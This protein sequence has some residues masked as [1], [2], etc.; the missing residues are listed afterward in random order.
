MKKLIIFLAVVL[1]I[2]LINA[3]SCTPD[4]GYDI[5]SYNFQQ[6]S[7]GGMTAFASA[8]I[9][10]SNIEGNHKS[11]DYWVGPTYIS[12]SS[13]GDEA[14]IYEGMSSWTNLWNI[15][16]CGTNCEY[17]ASAGLSVCND[18][19]KNY[20]EKIN[21]YSTGTY[22][23]TNNPGEMYENTIAFV[24]SDYN[25]KSNNAGWLW[26]WTATGAGWASNDITVRQVECYEDSDC[27]SG[28][29]CDRSGVWHQW[30]CTNAAVCSDSDGLDLETKGTCTDTNGNTYTDSC[31]SNDEVME[32]TCG[33]G[34]SCEPDYYQC[35]DSTCHDGKCQELEQTCEDSD[36]GKDYF[37]KGVVAGQNTDGSFFPSTEENTR[38]RCIGT[39]PQ[40]YVE[41]WYCDSYNLPKSVQ[42][43]CDGLCVNDACEDCDSHADERC[44]GDDLYWYDSCNNKE[45]LKEQCQYGCLNGQC[46][47]PNC[48]PIHY[49]IICD[50]D[51]DL[52]FVD[53][54]G[55]E[56]DL[57]LD[58]TEQE[59][60]NAETEECI[61]DCQ[62]QFDKICN[63]GNIWWVDSCGELEFQFG[64]D[65]IEGCEE[66]ACT[67][68]VCTP[69]AELRC[70]DNSVYQYDSCGNK[71][72][73]VKDCGSKTC[74]NGVCQGNTPGDC[75]PNNMR[76]AGNIVQQCNSQGN[77]WSTL[78]DCGTEAV[79]NEMSH[80]YA[81]CEKKGFF[82]NLIEKLKTDTT[83]QVGAIILVI[84]IA[85]VAITEK[86]RR[87]K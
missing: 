7:G 70:D 19:C 86:K 31:R 34:G 71:G 21:G 11:G 53:K 12:Y 78:H 67:G 24:S 26:V 17:S 87:N 59:Q 5:C 83:Y 76:C 10:I 16:D 33:L 80:T 13:N 85:F 58:C 9:Q 49:E 39:S 48:D 2:P 40:T 32:Y 61:A 52:R 68:G 44:V 46:T 45:D 82:D 60:C 81:I 77:E 23:L 6:E 28:K 75:T 37:T 74:T 65:C 1:M 27:S 66:G 50:D 25:F 18:I 63:E 64:P 14:Y 35:Y 29:V 54:C 51:G 47:G 69:N 4:S 79:C 42:Y 43:E 38:D 57:Y 56:N 30:D 3:T 62:T 55:A 41:E 72:D 20:H 8:Q 15:A 36:N 22:K 73:F 84:I